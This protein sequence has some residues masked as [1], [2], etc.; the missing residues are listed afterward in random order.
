MHTHIKAFILAGLLA[1]LLPALGG[2]AE[3][4]VDYLNRRDREWVK[5]LSSEVADHRS[6]APRQQLVLPDR[7]KRQPQR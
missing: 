1:G 2:A 4:S 5:R 3:N 7:P 6:I